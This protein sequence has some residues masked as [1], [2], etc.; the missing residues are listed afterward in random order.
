MF[1]GDVGCVVEGV[2]AVHA[3]VHGVSGHHNQVQPG[4][5]RFGMGTVRPG[6]QDAGS[7]DEGLEMVSVQPHPLQPVLCR[8]G[9]ETCSLQL[10]PERQ[11]FVGAVPG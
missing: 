3:R 10:L 2:P 7:T 9:E 5:R 4:L 1:L 11:P 8:Q 6:L